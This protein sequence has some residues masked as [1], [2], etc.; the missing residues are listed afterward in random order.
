MITRS[1]KRSIEIQ[2]KSSSQRDDL[3]RSI[4]DFDFTEDELKF[5]Q[6]LIPGSED[7]P[8]LFIFWDMDN[9]DSFLPKIAAYGGPLAAPFH[10]PAALTKNNLSLAIVN[11]WR[12]GIVGIPAS[13]RGMCV[14]G[15]LFQEHL[16]YGNAIRQSFNAWWA[17]VDGAI[18]G[19]TSLP[20]AQL[21]IL[22]PRDSAG[23]LENVC[24][25]P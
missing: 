12:A 20:L 21:Y 11:S 19:N 15:T 25:F 7:D 14:P 4:F 22:R 18:A 6:E 8:P 5:I 24:A 23:R 9:L 17:A 16:L 13:I 3:M 2:Q 1:R 10:I